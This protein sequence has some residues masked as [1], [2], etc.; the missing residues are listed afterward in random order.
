M[1]KASLT[2]PGLIGVLAVVIGSSTAARAADPAGENQADPFAPPAETPAA[3]PAETDE[4]ALLRAPDKATPPPQSP[5][6]APPRRTAVRPKLRPVG[7]A[8][9]EV[10]ATAAT[11]EADQSGLALELSTSSFA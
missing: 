5:P 8:T 11:P 9:D 4:E 3:P 1:K 6:P 2:C 10:H 7:Q